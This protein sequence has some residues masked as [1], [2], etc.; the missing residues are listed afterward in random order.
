M[1]PSTIAR[2]LPCAVSSA[3]QFHT[4]RPTQAS[5]LFALASLSNSRETQHF[6]KLSRLPR[7][8]HSPPLKL[9]ETSEVHPY[10]LP[11]PPPAPVVRTS[12]AAQRDARRVWDTKALAVG[13]EILLRNAERV[14]SLERRLL[15]AQRK[16][17]AKQ[18]AYSKQRYEQQAEIWKLRNEIRVAGAWILASIGAC[19]ALA[20]WRFWP[21]AAPSRVPVIDSGLLGREIAGSKSAAASAPAAPPAVAAAPTVV[22]VQTE[23]SSV[24]AGAAPSQF[25]G[26]TAKSSSWLD[27]W[28]WKQT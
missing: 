17:Q 1:A 4:S 23:T 24:M 9:I 25:S 16:A 7:V 5:V 28:F 11:T 15:K 21:G 19:T 10:P 20:T 14:G 12:K 18:T 6:G 26:P 13:R 8:E 2:S 3:R 22:P 27:G